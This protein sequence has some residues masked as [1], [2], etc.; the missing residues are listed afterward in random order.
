MNTQIVISIITLI[1][2]I[3]SSLA[4]I[5]TVSG[6]LAV[7]QAIADEK[8]RTI[9]DQ[10]KEV[11][12]MSKDIPIMQYQIAEIKTRQDKLDGLLKEIKEDQN[13]LK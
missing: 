10:L 4:T 8:I 1:G 12:M 2:V 11:V 9:N 3:I 13:D 7:S 6:K 5:F